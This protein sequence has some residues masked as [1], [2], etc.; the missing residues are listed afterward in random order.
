MDEGPALQVHT[1]SRRFGATLALDGLSFQ[2]ARG[3]LFGLVGPDGAGKSTVIRAL[4]G[5][6]NVDGGHTRVL[7]RDPAQGGSAVRESLGLMP[8]QASLYPDLS[9]AENLRFFARLYCLPR[10]LYGERRERL[11]AIT[12]K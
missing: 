8:Q 3:Q 12:C 4:A 5:L 7:G 6:I 2:V 11:L 9:V 1:L 10:A